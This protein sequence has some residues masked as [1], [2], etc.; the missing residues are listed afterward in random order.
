MYEQIKNGKFEEVGGLKC[1]TP[2]PPIDDNLILFSQYAQEDQFWRR[3]SLP[4]WWGETYAYEQQKRQNDPRY[5]EP[6]LQKFRNQEWARRLDG[7]HCLINNEITFLTGPTYFYLNWWRSDHPEND[8]YP[9]YYDQIR[10]RFYFRQFCAEDPLCLGYVIAGSRGFGKS[11]EE[12]AVITEDIT[13]P[14]TRRRAILQSKSEDDARDKIFKVKIMP[15][16]NA[17]PEFYKPVSNHGSLNDT[18]LSFFR[19]AIRGKQAKDVIY[20][21]AEELQNIITYVSAKEKAISGDSCASILQDE[22]GVTD[23]KKEADVDKRVQH[24]R[25][26]VYRN[27]IKRGLIRATTTVEE[28]D[29]G[30]AEFKKVWDKSDTRKRTANGFTLS[31][32]YRLFVKDLETTT[33]FADKYGKIDELR[34]KLFHD[35]ERKAREKDHAEFLSYVRKNPREER[36]MFIVKSE[37]CHFDAYGLTQRYEAIMNLDVKPYRIGNFDWVNGI[38]H[39]K[40]EWIP[41]FHPESEYE[42]DKDTGEMYC[43]HCRYVISY[44]PPEGICNNVLTENY[45]TFTQ[46]TPQNDI[47]FRAGLDPFQNSLVLDESRGSKAGF[48]IKLKYDPILD[49]PEEPTYKHFTDAPC[50]EYLSRPEDVYDMFEDVLKAL[51]YYGCPILPETNKPAFKEWLKQNGYGGFLLMKPKGI[52]TSDDVLKPN[53]DGGANST[54]PMISHYTDLIQSDVKRNVNKYCFPRLIYQLLHFDNSETK[55]WDAAV[56]WGFTLVGAQ[57]KIEEPPKTDD[58]QFWRTYDANGVEIR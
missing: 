12:C 47:K 4:E 33:Q 57:K 25:F 30:G 16:Y 42:A 29:K 13:R 3:T 9:I 28:M 46:Y 2:P 20:G 14:P 10:R 11:T 52:T 56:A 44:L 51:W 43:R 48:Y 15:S 17:L 5:K 32:L 36:E 41:C 31:G 21:D 39:G 22:I 50:L 40:I 6:K 37:H 53:N 18:K 24:N 1:W 27:N 19:P 34:A 55:K 8:G 58:V 54:S 26:A 23:P 45:G 35:N 7:I 38:R 49:N